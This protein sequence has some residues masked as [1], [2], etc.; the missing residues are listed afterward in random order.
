MRS[1]LIGFLFFHW[2]FWQLEVGQ[3]MTICLLVLNLTLNHETGSERGILRQ[4]W[5]RLSVDGQ[6]WLRFQIKQTHFNTY[7]GKFE[8]NRERFVKKIVI[9]VS[10]D[11]SESKWVLVQVNQPL[12]VEE[13]SR[14]I[15]V[16]SIRKKSS[17]IGP[18]RVEFD[19]VRVEYNIWS[20]LAFEPDQMLV[21]YPCNP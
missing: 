15:L 10:V 1:F 19:L 20:L 21:L 9:K 14:K 17:E 2:Y 16:T 7:Q 5:Q 18:L 3:T 6:R 12:D 11:T 8:I 13:T 4:I